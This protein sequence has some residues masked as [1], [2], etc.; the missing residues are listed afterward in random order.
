MNPEPRK[1]LKKMPFPLRDQVK[2]P[3]PED[4]PIEESCRRTGRRPPDKDEDPVS[5]GQNQPG[6]DPKG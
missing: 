3:R 1:P 2:Y 4:E 5:H 6:L